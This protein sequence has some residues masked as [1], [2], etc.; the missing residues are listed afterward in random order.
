MVELKD[1]VYFH[2]LYN[3]RKEDFVEGV[4]EKERSY[5]GKDRTYVVIL[6]QIQKK[7]RTLKSYHN[8]YSVT[9][10]VFNDYKPKK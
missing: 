6:K 1:V 2:Q 10:V 8:N 7:Q 3:L 4:K 5:T 9:M